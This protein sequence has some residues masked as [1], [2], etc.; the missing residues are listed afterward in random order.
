MIKKAFELLIDSS[1]TGLLDNQ[2]YKP[3]MCIASVHIPATDRTRELQEVWSE[4]DYIFTA[5][6]GGNTYNFRV[7][8]Q[9]IFCEF[10]EVEQP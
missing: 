3:Q 4:C 7:P 8:K 2:L 6:L 5:Q 10:V 9:K 1:L